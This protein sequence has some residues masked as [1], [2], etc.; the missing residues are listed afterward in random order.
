[1]N[2]HANSHSTFCHSAQRIEPDRCHARTRRAAGWL[3]ATLLAVVAVLGLAPAAH[4]QDI[5]RVTPDGGDSA[6]GSDWTTNAA[7]L[8]HAL[9][10]AVSGDEIWVA[11]G[12]YT[13]GVTISDTF[14]VISGIQ[15]YGGFAATETLRTQR[16]WVANP[17]VL[18]GDVGGDDITDA[19]G[20]V[21][22]TTNIVGANAYHVLWLDGA[23]GTPITATTRI[24]GFTITAGSAAGKFPH[25]S[26][27]GL[28]CAGSGS[29]NE[30]S[31]AIA[32]MKFAGN[33]AG[34][35]GGAM[36]NN[37]YYSG[38]SSPS[39]ENVIFSGNWADNGG[40][41]MYNNGSS[42]GLSSP[43]LVNVTISDNASDALY[44]GGGAM[45]NDGTGGGTSSPSLV[46][47][48]F[49]G[50]SVSSNG[51]AIYNDSQNSGGIS[52]P[53]LV[54]VIFSGNRASYGGAMANKATFGGT[55]SPSLVNVTFSGN[56]ATSRGGAM[57]SNGA[58]SPNLV[59]VIMWGNTAS[60]GAQIFNDD[61]TV[62]PIISYTL[63]SMT[64]IFNGSSITW[65]PGNITDDS[66]P[67]FVAPVSASSA[68]TTSG[69][70]RLTVTS[71]AIN[72]GLNSAVPSGV[73]TDL[74]GNP[75]IQDGTVE[76]GAY[77]Q[78]LPNIGIAK[79]A[80]PA[81]EVSSGAVLTYALVLSNTGADDP[82]VLVTDTLPAE[83]DFAGWIEQSGAE[84][85]N[86][87]I[88]WDGA[89]NAGTTV[90]VS[91]QITNAAG[92][93]AT[94]TNTAWFSG[95]TRTGNAAAAY[96]S[97]STLTPSGS[98][99]WGD[100]FPPCSG[101]CNYVI[102]PGVTVALDQD[103]E[104]SGN[105]TIESGGTF[106]ANGKTVMLTGDQAQT[107]TGNPLT[108]YSLVV[109]KTN[110][111]DTVTIVGKLKVTRKLTVRSGKLISASDYGDIEIEENGE[112]QLTSDI[113]VSGHF[114]NSGTFEIGRASCRE[115]V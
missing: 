32:N 1:M 85:D 52:S 77:E 30:C 104:L 110:R 34:G 15:L 70:Y 101:I 108:F 33:S 84:V 55:T 24:D 10:I 73:T 69:D 40:A 19:S 18:S 25:N 37:G 72:A 102:P 111:T 106:N 67:L 14:T 82:A 54:N 98:G 6:N 94:I 16:D 105:L 99:N 49:S 43:S 113:T 62:T 91:F 23:S 35:N 22:T 31:P 41:A 78:R 83:V 45:Y 100:I 53:S 64:G 48:T 115:R 36:Y 8:Q 61:T 29:G 42:G 59:N 46:N 90:T 93:G 109:N 79:L 97:S 60:V 95:S 44:S 96:T 112:L 13:P 86:D 87:V 107:L 27:G 66:D 5:I 88:T 75:R 50:N 80:S 20:V 26:G 3:L 63:V 39:L 74:D 56:R 68:P 17:T 28:Y 89:L 11:G 58:S 81:N 7:S 38:V 103:I 47:V 21:V 12:I 71:P 4:A 114:T 57:W 65:G 9:S 2:A 76:M 51:G 92:G